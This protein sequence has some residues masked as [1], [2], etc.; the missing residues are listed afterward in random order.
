MYS[1]TKHHDKK[2]RREHLK[3][4]KKS[5]EAIQ[6]IAEVDEELIRDQDHHRNNSAEVQ[7]LEALN[8]LTGCMS[9][10]SSKYD[11]MAMKFQEKIERLETTSKKLEDKFE[12]L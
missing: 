6:A 8:M 10:I 9:D 11:M 2:Q 1:L 4:A 5:P 3:K 7:E 12:A